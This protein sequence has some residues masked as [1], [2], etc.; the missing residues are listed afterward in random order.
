MIK[1]TS[2]LAFASAFADCFSSDI[3]ER[4]NG[5]TGHGARPKLAHG[6]G[7]QV[8]AGPIMSLRAEYT[9]KRRT[10]EYEVLLLFLD[11]ATTAAAIP[12]ATVDKKGKEK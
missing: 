3:T 9:S 10:C 8:R 2:V 12:A 7:S 5:H 11:N 4:R 6:Q 1:M